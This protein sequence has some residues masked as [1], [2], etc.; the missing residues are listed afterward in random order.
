MK[1]KKLLLVVLALAILTSLSAGTLAV[2]TRTDT[3]SG[4]TDV[5]KFA[6]TVKGGT[7][8]KAIKL[9]PTESVDYDF[10]LT[11]T[12]SL[13]K[14]DDP[15]EV[16]LEYL[17]NIDFAAAQATMNGLRGTLYQVV[18]GKKVEKGTLDAGG[19]ISFTEDSEAGIYFKKEYRLVL[20]WNEGT[21]V[22]QTKSGEAAVSVVQG[23][24]V[25]VN[26]T[27]VV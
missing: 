19:K 11:N 27:Q 13:D 9:A 6:F 26:A 25:S 14:T 4:D 2:Y 5:K 7:A 17:V 22:D 8:N 3:I 1:M 20:S 21:N 18:D 23:L 24:K 12:E 10:T 16:A 15:A